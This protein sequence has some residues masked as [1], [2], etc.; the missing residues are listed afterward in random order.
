MVCSVRRTPPAS[1]SGRRRGLGQGE[2]TCLFPINQ[3][4]TKG[5]CL[6]WTNKTDS[7]RVTTE[8]YKYMGRESW[9]RRRSAGGGGSVPNSRDS[10]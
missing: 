3:V 2:A 5:D 6:A 7:L 9:A 4:E 10:G 8:M 1:S